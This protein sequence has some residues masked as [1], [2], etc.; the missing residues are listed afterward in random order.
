MQANAEHDSHLDESVRGIVGGTYDIVIAGAGHNSLITAAYLARAGY[1]CVILD[2]RPVVGGGAVT[3]EPLLPGYRVDTCSTGHTLIQV[4]PLIRNDEL[5][6]VARYGLEYIDPD[7]VEHVVFPDGEYLTMCLE[8]ERT[9]EEIARFSERDAEAYRRLIEEYDEVK[10]KIG[11][12]RFRPVG[13]GPSLDQVLSD[14]PIWMRRRMM[15]A[16]D[17]IAHTFEERHV[18]S[19]M[20]WVAS[21]T[22]VPLDGAGSGLLAYQIVSGRQA[23]SWSI[24]RGGSGLLIDSLVGFLTDHGAEFHTDAKVS[25]LIIDD[26][27]C[28]GVRT[29]AGEEYRAREAVVSTIHVKHLLDMAPRQLWGEPFAYGVETYDVGLP[30]FAGYFAATEAPVFATEGGGRSAVSAGLAGWLDDIAAN[31]RRVSNGLYSE[32][33]P[34]FLVATPT[35][36]DPGRAPN[37]HH[38]VKFV[39]IN[40]YDVDGSGPE[41]WDAIK[42]DHLDRQLARVQAVAPNFT[43]DVIIERLAKSPLDI[44]RDNPHMV[45]GAPHGGDRGITFSG[46][47][48]PVPGWAQHRMPI[49][50]LYQTGG[51]T[52]PGGSITGAP[53]RNAAW[54]LL[55]DLGRDPG[56]VMSV[57]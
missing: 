6:L 32:V 11:G 33:D 21:Q 22:A 36:A 25:E 56:E 42:D 40:A 46:A 17:V 50:G 34:W 16:R 20:G 43:E 54:I 28:V 5:G 47:Q 18:R 26:D 53:G 31:G 57:E 8:L 1:S 4:N 39:T 7:P 9:C 52:H 3:E 35:L 30:F 48:R 38:T 27:R 24:P 15:S 14:H 2:A 49:S 55:E 45:H 51:T 37:G 23:R 19:F 12:T 44:E 10:A 29:D 41:S 13:R